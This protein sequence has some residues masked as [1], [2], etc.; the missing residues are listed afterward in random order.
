MKKVT[1]KSLL[2]LTAMTP[3]ILF[4]AFESVSDSFN[5][6]SNSAQ[7]TAE[8]SNQTQTNID[9]AKNLPNSYD[10]DA[11]QYATQELDK[12]TDNSISK[13]Q[14]ASNNITQTRDTLAKTSKSLNNLFS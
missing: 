7:K 13:T 1:I 5:T 11:K 2:T 3:S 10:S 14:Q 4:A 8:I 9:K 12:H 6:V